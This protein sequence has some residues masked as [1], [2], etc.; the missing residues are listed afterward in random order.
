M[1][2]LAG[3][4]AARGKPE[5]PTYSVRMHDGDPAA[6]DDPGPLVTVYEAEH[7][8]EAHT[9]AAVLADANIRAFVFSGSVLGYADPI[10]GLR[11][12]VP[13]QVAEAHLERARRALKEAK[14]IGASIDWDS[15]DVGE[16]EPDHRVTTTITHVLLRTLVGL[17]WLA[18]VVL[19][20]VTIV[21]ALIFLFH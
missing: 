21:G 16:D 17:G 14:Y 7:E 12:R 2:E 13:V 9:V 11:G 18:G 3:P 19:V 6:H 15:V 4:P 1:T 10:F 5:A 20:L 8:F